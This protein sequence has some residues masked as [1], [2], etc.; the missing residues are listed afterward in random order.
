M[1]VA[2]STSNR[3]LGIIAVCM[4]AAG[5]AVV[6]WGV[7]EW[8]QAGESRSW[9]MTTGTVVRSYVHNVQERK[10]DPV[11]VRYYPKVHYRYMVRGEVYTADRIAFGGHI[12]TNQHEAQKM[13]DRYPTGSA[14]TVAYDPN[15]PSV[16]VLNAGYRLP[17][18]AVVGAGGVIC[19]FGILGYRMWRRQQARRTI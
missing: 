1:I 7:F 4:V 16:A 9:P 5:L 3:R 18:V 13:V 2:T 19:A 6:I 8:K 12:E 17:A 14:V 10:E 15:D 11:M